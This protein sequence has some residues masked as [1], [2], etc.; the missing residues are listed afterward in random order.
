M[1]A[2]TIDKI[3]NLL[4][5]RAVALAKNISLYSS[6]CPLCVLVDGENRFWKY[7]FLPWDAFAVYEKDC[8]LQCRNP[9][10][11]QYFRVFTVHSHSIHDHAFSM[12]VLYFSLAF[13]DRNSYD[14]TVVE[15]NTVKPRTT[16]MQFK[17]ERNVGKTGVM[18]IGL[19]GN[20]GW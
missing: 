4:E 6:K 9:R 14:T 11:R 2:E 7:V 19:G 13:H 20:N 17:T 1:T 16:K 12:I 10:G 8:L 18:L 5:S 15:G 3:S